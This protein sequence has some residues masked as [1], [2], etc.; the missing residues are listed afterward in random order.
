MKNG[1]KFVDRK[2]RIHIVLA[3]ILSLFSAGG[4]SILGTATVIEFHVW[5]LVPAIIFAL[6]LAYS[7][8]SIYSKKLDE[9]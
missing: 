2:G 8:Y 5:S 4:M 6:A 3:I 9:I 1:I 7:L